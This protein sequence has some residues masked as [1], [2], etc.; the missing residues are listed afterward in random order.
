MDTSQE[1]E[2]RRGREAA[3]FLAGYASVRELSIGE[4]EVLQLGPAVHHIFLMGL[5]LRY[6][7]VR[8]GWHWAD[9]D[10]IDWHMKWF[11]HWIENH[12]KT[13]R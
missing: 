4:L 12:A 7:S 9:D 8:D 2:A 5:V 10:F 3:Q 6:W 11:R 13:I 1:G